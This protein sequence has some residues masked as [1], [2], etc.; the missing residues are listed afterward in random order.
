MGI[1]E[2]PATV[3]GR[4]HEAMGRVAVGSV[5][6]TLTFR[7]WLIGRHIVEYERSGSDRA[8]YGTN[9]VPRLAR[10]R[11]EG[12]IARRGFSARNLQLFRKFYR[13]YP[14]ISAL[15]TV[16]LPSTEL[17][18]PA[19]LLVRRFSFTHFVELLRLTDPLKRAF[20]GG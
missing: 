7:N 1:F 2:E 10:R 12:A 6:R 20:Y 8:E 19:S 3:I 14:Q 5:N 16:E 15:V 17:S 4:V 13:T 9:P 18:A 11:D